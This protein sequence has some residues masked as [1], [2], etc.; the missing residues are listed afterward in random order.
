MPKKLERKQVFPGDQIAVI[1]EFN[2]GTGSYEYNGRIISSEI[3]NTKYDMEKRLIKVD[4][5]TQELMLPEERMIV[6]AE[7]G[8]VAKRD[9][10][11][12]IFR[13]EE[14]NIHPSYSGVIHISDIS[15]EYTKNIDMALRNGDIIKA[16][17]VNTKNNLNQCSMA[18]PELGVVYAYCSKCGGLLEK[19]RGKLICPDCGKVERRKIAISYGLEDFA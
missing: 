5:S 15:R 19:D 7:V 13:L 2:F 3:G 16:K 10:R 9:A 18:E 4:K 14:N 17:L 8:S 11:I 6:F 12:E 1:E